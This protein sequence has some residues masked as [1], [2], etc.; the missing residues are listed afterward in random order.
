M[1]ISLEVTMS[2]V[3]CTVITH[4]YCLGEITKLVKESNLIKKKFQSSLVFWN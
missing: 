1:S 2:T 3:V 4:D